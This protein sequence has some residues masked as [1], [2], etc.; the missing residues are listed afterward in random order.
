M[1]TDPSRPSARRARPA[2]P[3]RK[4]EALDHIA[5]TC[6]SVCSDNLEAALESGSRTSHLAADMGRSYIDVCS[7]FAVE[8]SEIARESLTCRSPSDV[9]ALQDKALDVLGTTFDAS[10]KVYG[11]LFAGYNRALEPVFERAMGGPERMLQAI[12]G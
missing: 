4:H 5:Q 11:D 3:S 2:A 9:M 10:R 1:P 7:A 12:A 8:M 6:M